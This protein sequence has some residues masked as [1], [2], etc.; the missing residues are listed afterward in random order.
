M[1]VWEN[2]NKVGKREVGDATSV[3][4]RIFANLIEPALDGGSPGRQCV[5][6]H[7]TGSADLYFRRINRGSA[8]PGA[9]TVLDKSGR[10]TAGE[11]APVPV[12]SG[13]ELYLLGSTYVAEEDL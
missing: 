12:D 7:N 8:A 9:I 13:V 2:T 4:T 1:Q 10:V 3:I 5:W 11:C 6:L